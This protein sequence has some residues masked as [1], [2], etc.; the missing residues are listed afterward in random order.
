M[1]SKFEMVRAELRQAAADIAV[2]H[3]MMTVET[4]FDDR[5]VITLAGERGARPGPYHPVRIEMEIWKPLNKD[6]SV[7]D[8]EA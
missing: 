3:G 5:T 1:K 8:G 6:H 2:K 7:A 4:A